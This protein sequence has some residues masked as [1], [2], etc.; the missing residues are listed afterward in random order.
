M[1]RSSPLAGRVR[2]RRR[3]PLTRLIRANFY[4]TLLLLGESWIVLAGFGLLALAGTLYMRSAYGMG[5]AAALYETLKLL[6]F[7]SGL[8]LPA[9]TL[10]KALFFLIPLLG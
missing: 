7:Q 8:A 6:T 5:F 2:Q 10:G 9:D 1:A 4:D 3:F